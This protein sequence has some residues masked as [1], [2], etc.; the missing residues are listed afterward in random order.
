MH[1]V[2]ESMVREMTTM[3]SMFMRFKARSHGMHWRG[4][5]GKEAME[6][7]ISCDLIC[8]TNVLVVIR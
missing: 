4:F 6:I 3:K 8:H 1:T 2:S 7:E 5:C